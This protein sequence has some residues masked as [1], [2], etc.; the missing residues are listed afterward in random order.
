M[1]EKNANMLWNQVEDIHLYNFFFFLF[2]VEGT[3]KADLCEGQWQHFTI[4]SG[5]VMTPYT[6]N[7]CTPA[8]YITTVVPWINQHFPLHRCSLMH[9]KTALYIESALKPCY[10]SCLTNTYGAVTYTESWLVHGSVMKG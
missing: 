7:D 10:Y 8:P 9:E 1:E 6:T 3:L 4:L 5:A 2:T